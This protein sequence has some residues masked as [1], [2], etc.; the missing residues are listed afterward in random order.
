[1]QEIKSKQG[2]NNG[3]NYFFKCGNFNR[4]FEAQ[5]LITPNRILLIYPESF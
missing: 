5:T 4:Q 3:I 1:M 2:K